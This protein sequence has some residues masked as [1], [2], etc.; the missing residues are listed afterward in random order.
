MLDLR[1]PSVLLLGALLAAFPAAGEADHERAR[2]AVEA[3]RTRPLS[4]ILEKVRRD[5]PGE[6]IDV[7]LEDDHHGRAGGDAPLI[8]EV[9]LRTPDG[10][11]LK[12]EYDAATGALRSI[13]KR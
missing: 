8:Y 2:A 10:R 7:E 6:V 5:H 1:L 12:L 9:K 4:E 3:G 13:R 11:I